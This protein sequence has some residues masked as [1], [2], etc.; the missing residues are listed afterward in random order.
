MVQEEKAQAGQGAAQSRRVSTDGSM[1]ALKRAA[2]AAAA[3]SSFKV[4]PN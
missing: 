4:Q 1:A 3:T 2:V